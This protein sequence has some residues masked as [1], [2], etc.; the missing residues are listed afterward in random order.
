MLRRM[1][2][3][4]ARIPQ[5]IDELNS[6]FGIIAYQL[7]LKCYGEF[8]IVLTCLELPMG[9]SQNLLS[10]EALTVVLK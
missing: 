10:D 9:L 1:S 4:P 7:T 8:L 5:N 6:A 2:T 3:R